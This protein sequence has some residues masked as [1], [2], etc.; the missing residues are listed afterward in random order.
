MDLYWKFIK[1]KQIPLEAVSGRDHYWHF[2]P[3]ISGPAD[4]IL[5]KVVVPVGGGHP[6]HRHPEMNEI[7]Y[8]LKGRA[9]QWVEE[10]LQMMEVGDS[11]YIAPDVIHATYNA[12]DE[13]LEFLAV[14]APASGWGAG[15]IDESMNPRYTELRKSNN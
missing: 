11:V 14:L 5:V 10:E 6:F 13:P 3:E 1:A 7:L 15:T 8:I 2:N 12:G 4:T 9:E